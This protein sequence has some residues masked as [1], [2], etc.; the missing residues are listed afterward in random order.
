[1][2]KVA[3]KVENVSKVYKL[4]NKPVDRLKEA[5]NPFAKEYHNQFYAVKD[6]SFQI[7]QGE[8]IG[9]IGKNG[10]GKSTLLKMITN[11]LSPSSGEI[12]VNGHISALLELG[13]GFNPEFTGIENI[14]MNGTVMG[15]SKSEMKSK[16]KDILDFADIGDFVHQPVRLYSSGMFVR[17]AFAVAISI[18]PEI[19]IVDEALAVGDIAF[20]NKCF[21]KFEA[22][23]KAGKTI[24]FVTHSLDLVTR[25]CDRAIL[26]NDGVVI[27]DGKPNDVVN[28]FT[29]MMTGTKEKL[30]HIEDVELAHSIVNKN[31]KTRE[32]DFFSSKLDLF[33]TRRSYNPSEF[34]WGDNRVQ[35]YDY[36]LII[37]G[38]QDPALVHANREVELYV[39]F[40]FNEK[41]DKFMCGIILKTL[42]GMVVFS[43]NTRMESIQIPNETG[44]LLI[45][46]YK[47]IARLLSGKYTFSIGCSEDLNDIGEDTRA[48]DRRNDAILIEVI[49][50]LDSNGVLDP[51]L[52]FDI[53]DI[54]S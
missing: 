47:F 50:K 3:I 14:F 13:A 8:T 7:M 52:L 21:R 35:I 49:N 31:T 24:L 2:S 53:L 33:K 26:I 15:Y 20:Q 10:S 29:E 9:I 11:V 23:K 4:Y 28:I 42:D 17:L 48:L 43:Y 44:T 27:S 18:E 37:N 41:V 38:E 45:V 1:M 6:V 19:L 32:D 34:R 40:M 39:K 36:A 25:H 30:K 51:N 22:L 12:T 5:I 54:N 16:L 46:R